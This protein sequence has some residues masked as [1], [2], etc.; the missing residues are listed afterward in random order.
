MRLLVSVVNMAEAIEAARGGAQIIDVKDPGAGAL[1][2]APPSSIREVRDATPPGLPVSAALG[3]GPFEPRLAA[4]AAALAAECGAS[5]VKIGLRETSANQALD[6]L[7]AVRASLPPTVHLIVAGFADF[8]RA[9]SPD[10]LDL[11]LLAQAAG[12]QGFLA[13]TAVKDGRGLLHWLDDTALRSLVTA[14]RARGLLCALAGSLAPADLP[15]LAAIGPDIVGVRGAAC[16]GDRAHG[17][18]TRERV[19]ALI[20]ALALRGTRVEEEARAARG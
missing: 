13:D 5:F 6:T 8:R 9:G 2:A 1:G 10:P 11:P 19:T 7:R 12:A 18:V 3:D 14:C 4:R 16:A 20:R 17:R 15:L